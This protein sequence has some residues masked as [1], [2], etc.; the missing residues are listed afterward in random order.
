MSFILSDPELVKLLFVFWLPAQIVHLIAFIIAN[1]DDIF[2]DWKVFYLGDIS[3]WGVICGVTLIWVNFLSISIWWLYGYYIFHILILS[4]LLSDAAMYQ[5][6]ISASN[7]KAIFVETMVESILIP[8]GA[9]IGLGALA[10]W[11]LW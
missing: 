7:I 2:L 5:E 9:G 8:W 11:L 3:G 4:T 6:T 10:A 1:I